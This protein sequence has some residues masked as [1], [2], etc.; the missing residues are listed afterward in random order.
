MVGV[1]KMIVIGPVYGAAKYSDVVDEI[2]RN[3]EEN[4][5]P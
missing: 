4:E 3:K 1:D 2:L 5:K